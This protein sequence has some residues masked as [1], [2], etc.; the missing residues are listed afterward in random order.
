[1]INE[2]LTKTKIE[3][4]VEFYKKHNRA[5]EKDEDRDLCDLVYHIRHCE[6]SENG[7]PS[8]KR[9][10]PEACEFIRELEKKNYIKSMLGK[11]EEFITKND[12]IPGK[13]KKEIELL[14]FYYWCKENEKYLT[15]YF[16]KE[17][18][19]FIYQCEEDFILSI[20]ID[21]L[22]KRKEIDKKKTEIDKKIHSD[23]AL[24]LQEKSLKKFYT[25][26]CRLDELLTKV[27]NLDRD[28][29]NV[30]NDY[31]RFFDTPYLYGFSV[32]HDLDIM[33]SINEFLQSEIEL[34]DYLDK[35]SERVVEGQVMEINN[36]Y[37]FTHENMYI[38]EVINDEANRLTIFKG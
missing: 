30:R 35:K 21:N 22:P 12:R 26:F 10:Y 1:M 7:Y 8:L 36:F 3:K 31:Y 6:K 28:R 16:G 20:Q 38:K 27:R 32:D 11:L 15:N 18:F 13:T 2:E 37:Y 23:P 9:R 25:D 19:S 33:S 29:E 5:P 24:K 34:N 14:M 4:L 17:S